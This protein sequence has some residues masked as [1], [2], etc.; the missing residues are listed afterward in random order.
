MISYDIEGPGYNPSCPV[1]RPHLPGHH[2]PSVDP[3]APG[4]PRWWRS[5]S[6]TG[7]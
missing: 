6:P 1:P 2:S 3:V 4:M 7:P 5:C